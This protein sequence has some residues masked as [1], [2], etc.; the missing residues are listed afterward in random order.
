MR[1]K[2]CKII[3]L[4]SILS[5]EVEYRSTQIHSTLVRVETIYFILSHHRTI[6]QQYDEIPTLFASINQ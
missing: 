3:E 6:V 5:F 2:I 4:K 1:K